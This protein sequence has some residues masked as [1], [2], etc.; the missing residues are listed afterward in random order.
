MEGA[1]TAAVASS[2]VPLSYA[3]A[4]IA[5]GGRV[6]LPVPASQVLY[7][8]FEH[9]AGV[10]APDGGPSLN[11]DRLKILD[12]LI[13]RLSSVRSE[14]LAALEAP[15]ELTPGRVDALIRQYGAEL[16][17]L[18][19]APAVPYAPRPAVPAGTLFSFAA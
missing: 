14:P 12:I 2:Y 13:E 19:A 17:A 1:M 8:S 3:H 18:A 4:V 15:R 10:A 7:S 11:V 6:S 5:G 16:H 9:V